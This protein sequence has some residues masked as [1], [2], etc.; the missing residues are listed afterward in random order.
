MRLQESS[1]WIR[2]KD[3]EPQ[4]LPPLSLMMQPVA[5]LLKQVEKNAFSFQV[6]LQFEEGHHYVAN[7][8]QR[9]KSDAELYLDYMVIS[10]LLQIQWFRFP[11]T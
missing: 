4:L 1:P 5:P 8:L 7:N 2:D 9:R 3:L 6:T 10:L 11:L